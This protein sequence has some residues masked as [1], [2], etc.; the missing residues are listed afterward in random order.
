MELLEAIERTLV[1]GQKAKQ[2]RVAIVISP[3][4][5]VIL[6]WMLLLFVWLS[7]YIYKLLNF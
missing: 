4:G 1:S 3:S 7:Y 6:E 5:A 2:M